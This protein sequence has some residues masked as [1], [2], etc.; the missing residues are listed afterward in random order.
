[1]QESSETDS[2]GTIVDTTDNPTTENSSIMD[3]VALDLYAFL[4]QGQNNLVDAFNSESGETQDN[5]TIPDDEITTDLTTTM[6]LVT[7]TIVAD[8]TTTSTTTTT[9]TEPTTTSTTTTEPSTT[10]TQTPAGRG[11]FRRPGIGGS[12]VSRNRY[13]RIPYSLL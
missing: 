10:T 7:T 13:P 1:M 9:T 6:E 12:A 4:Q 11:K 2:S 5:T 3:K 8:S